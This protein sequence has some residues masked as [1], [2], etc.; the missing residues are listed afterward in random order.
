MPAEDLKPALRAALRF[1]EIGDDTPYRLYFAGKGNSGASF[2][3]MQGDLNT[4]QETVKHTFQNVLA[5]ERFPPGEIASLI[6]RLSVHLVNS[7]LSRAEENAVNAALKAQ[8]KLVD[9][10]DEEI[11]EDVFED[12]DLCI[13]TAAANGREIDPKAQLYIAMWINMTGKPTKL[14]TWLRG[15]DPQL[16]EKI[17]KPGPKVDTK[18]IETYLQA[19]DYYTSNPRNFKHM[20]D[21]VAKGVPLI[22]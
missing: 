14:L 22:P 16:R 6:E 19:T 18:A 8:R 13:G 10:M 11:A 12:L 21:S 15:G 17:A 1:H 7:P 3:F 5:A 9:R 4:G 20:R 2:G